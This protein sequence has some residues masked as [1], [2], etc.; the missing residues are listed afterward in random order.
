VTETRGPTPRA[1]R[2]RESVLVALLL[3]AL[4]IVLTWPA[5]A[6][7]GSTVSDLGDPVLT[8][9]ILAWDVHALGATPLRLFDANMFHPRRGTLAYTEHLL[10]LVPLV[11]PARLL[12]AGPVFAHNVVWLATF[13]LTGLALFWLVRH[14]TGHAGAAT[15]AAVLYAFSHFRFGQLSHIQVLSHQWLPLMLL[16]LHRAAESGGRWRDVGLAAGAFALQ[17]LSSGYQAFF[18][19]IAGTLFMAWLV[20]P[21]TRP[22]LGRLIGRGSLAGCMVT[23]VLL[24]AFLPYRLTRDEISLTRNP[25]EIEHYVARPASYL[26]APAENRWLG[27]AT[28]RFRGREAA[29]FP[30]FVALALALPVSVRGWRQR[31]GAAKPDRG[32]VGRWPIALDVALAVIVLVTVANWLVLGGFTIRLGA[33]RVSQTHF[34]APVLGIAVAL[35][36]RRA[37]RGGPSPVRG[38]GWLRRLGWPSAPGYYLGLA[39]VGAIASFGPWLDLGELRIQPLY[40]QLLSVAP[41]FDVLRVPGRFGVLVMTGLAVLAGF[42]AAALAR[43]LPRP[44]WR[45]G[46]LGGLG[47]LA[48]LEAWAVPL[49]LMT[50][51]SGPGPADRWLAARARGSEAVLVLPMYEPRAVHLESLRLLGSTA[52]WR[53]L[54][55]GYGGVLPADYPADVSVLNTFPATAAVARLRAIHVRYVVVHLGQYHSEPRARLEAALALLPPGVARVATF[56]H[57]QIFEIGPAGA[58]TSGET[59]GADEV[60]RAR[61]RRGLG[62]ARRL[63]RVEALGDGEHGV[64]AV[65]LREEALASALLAVDQ[66]HEVLDDEAGGLQGL[67]GLQLR[68]AVRHDVVDDDDPLP[69]LERPFDAP[70]GAVCLCLAPRVDERE[71]A[72]EARGDGEREAGIRDTRDAV[73]PAARHLRRHQRAHLGQDRRVGDHH[74]QIDVEGRRD[75][76]LEHELAEAQPADLVEPPDE[77]TLA[78][79]AHAGISDRIA[80][81]AA[82]GSV[83]PV[84]GRPTTR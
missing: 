50:V 14:L 22:P 32:R 79:L 25:M 72:G 38:L 35:A 62:E 56:E 58:R 76:R 39:L 66:D 47:A 8:I 68:G 17:A 74:P 44:G 45:A 30:G 60:P 77:R 36:V 2:V 37:V 53:P 55:N 24:P 52:H 71:A 16:G 10:G 78:W 19:A 4:A 11:W 73:S 28:A 3:T 6:F 83:A 81:A 27:D 54:V 13:P 61:E 46:A 43:R 18:A 40:H 42:G 29:L 9:W 15:V 82:A 59:G 31:H 51:P 65:A 21:T 34:A 48:V 57:S 67:D 23:L 84:I 75:A 80:A 49:P 1:G 41:G 33:L 5:A 20:L 63:E 70:P 26:A 69:R 7:L 12:G 64:Q